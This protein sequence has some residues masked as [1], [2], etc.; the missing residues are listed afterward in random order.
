MISLSALV[1]IVG[2]FLTA[3]GS[4]IVEYREPEPAQAYHYFRLRLGQASMLGLEILVVA[5]VIGQLTTEPTFRSLAVLAFLA[6]LR[7]L[8]SWTFFLQVQGRWPWQAV[9]GD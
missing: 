9:K 5:S 6:A 3:V 2:G 4:Y 8:F 1:V 7:V